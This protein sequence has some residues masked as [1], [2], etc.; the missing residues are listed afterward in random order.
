MARLHVRLTKRKLPC[1]VQGQKKSGCADNENDRSDG[2]TSP[3]VASYRHLRIVCS[4]LGM[5][6]DP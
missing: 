3:D 2:I 6:E 1:P 4:L 5:I